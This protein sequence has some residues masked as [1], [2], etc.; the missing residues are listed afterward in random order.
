MLILH[1]D[2]AARTKA[3]A[4]S[5]HSK[6]DFNPQHEQSLLRERED[7]M[8]NLAVYRDRIDRAER[9]LVG[10]EFEFTPPRGFNRSEVHGVLVRLVT[11]RDKSYCTALEN[12]SRWKTLSCCC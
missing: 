8:N 7:Q 3:M 9:F 10:I 6:I 4:E 5:E 1:G 2:E 12:H 11:V